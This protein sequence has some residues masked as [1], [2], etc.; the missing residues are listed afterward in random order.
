LGANG[1]PIAVG[2]SV[3]VQ[4][5]V[6]A[7]KA[8]FDC[9]PG[10]TII[11]PPGGTSGQTFTPA[12]PQPFVVLSLTGAAPPPLAAPPPPPEVAAAASAPLA[13]TGSDPL[14]PVTFALGLLAAGFLAQAAAV[15]ARRRRP[16]R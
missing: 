1:A 3:F 11:N 10:T 12:T 2:G 14:G 5:T 4:A 7:I 8:N 6:A 13:R 16:A 15:Q 9:F